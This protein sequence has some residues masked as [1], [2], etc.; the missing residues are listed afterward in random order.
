MKNILYFTG[1]GKSKEGDEIFFKDS[2]KVVI[3]TIKRDTKKM[4]ITNMNI[5][6][7]EHSMISVGSDSIYVV[8]G[9]NSN[10]FIDSC[11]EYSIEKNT[12]KI[13]ALLNEKRKN[14]SLAVFDSKILYAFGG[15][16]KMSEDGSKIIESLDTSNKEVK[17]WT[18]VNLKIGTE[19]WAEIYYC[20]AI[21][22]STDTII[23]FGG[24]VNKKEI[25]DCYM[26]NVNLLSME[27]TEKLAK[28]D[29]FNKTRLILDMHE[30]MAVGRNN[31][32][33]CNLLDKKCT[34]WSLV[35][36][37]VYDIEPGFYIKSE[38]Y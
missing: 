32:H 35:E 7:S 30:V 4:A 20:G 5:A 25:D 2:Y 19:C 17:H 23:I 3:D 14:I 27:K 18:K 38:T 37:S 36:A 28:V 26:F 6:R 34:K 15:I 33:I 24:I 16:N 12:W 1:G 9:F 21:Q 11:E 10:T 22:I 13:C 8:G 29:V 31:I